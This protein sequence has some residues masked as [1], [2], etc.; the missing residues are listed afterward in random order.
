[1]NDGYVLS[2]DQ[3]TQGTKAL[4]INEKGQ[5]IARVDKA[6]Q[7]IIDESGYVSH[8]LQEIYANLLE[9]VKRVIDKAKIAPELIRSV[10]ISNQRE[11]S[12]VWNKSTQMPICDAVVWQCKRAKPNCQ[13]IEAK[14]YASLIREKTG[15]PLSPYF[16]ASKFA[17][18]LDNVEVKE[19]EALCFGTID[20]WLIF[21][22]TGGK[23]YK[24]DYSNASR[25]QLFNI[26]TLKWD[27]KLCNLFGIPIASLPEVCDS[28]SIFG[29][30]DFEG[31][32]PQKIPI[33][34]VLGDSHGAL[35]GQACLKR[36]MVKATYGTGSSVMMNVGEKPITSQNGLV[37]SLAW[38]IKGKVNYVLEGNIIYTGAVISW[39]KNDLEI[40][41]EASETEKL[42]FSANPQDT[43]YLVP[44]F[45]GLGAPY[46][47]DDVKG[48]IT[49]IT[50]TTK[51]AEIVKAGLECI[52]YQ[53]ND[54]IKAM[55]EDAKLEI[56]SL[57][58]DGGP[59]NNNYLMQ[60]QSDILDALVE[61]PEIE[62]L[63]AIGVA[64]VAGISIGLFPDNIVDSLNRKAF[65]SGFKEEERI[66]KQN[67]WKEAI[68]QTIK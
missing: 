17:W 25:T 41:K 20:T 60:F 6:H 61:V 66:K 34:G 2:V 37:T 12:A 62:E 53:I 58:V 28:D 35:F 33:S 30:T 14:G 31:V 38:K 32:L 44:A 13:K 24:T 22:L 43:T 42:A 1:M 29:E 39:L 47:Q 4:L 67:G 18:I 59:T 65:S 36:G 26:H 16:P 40:I 54:I 15:L 52:A 23:S 3:S 68:N 55:E 7:Q 21:K 48:I 19:K 57:R 10:G 63:S 5:I 11:T 46:W 50:R 45:T 8:N 56:K 49:G 51:K 9:V 27:E 64:F